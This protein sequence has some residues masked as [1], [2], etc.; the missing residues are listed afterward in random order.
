MN[1]CYSDHVKNWEALIGLQVPGTMDTGATPIGV[2][3]KL[4]LS[5]VKYLQG[6]SQTAHKFLNGAT[7]LS[8]R[9]VLERDQINIC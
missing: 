3:V 7:P 5:L 4:C 6:C 1:D 2:N 9:T 8:C